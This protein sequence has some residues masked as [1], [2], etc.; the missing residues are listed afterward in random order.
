MHS[1]TGNMSKLQ[2]G[3][4]LERI[5]DQDMEDIERLFLSLSSDQV[6]LAAIEVISKD[7]PV[8]AEYLT[9]VMEVAAKYQ[10]PEQAHNA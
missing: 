4:E 8:M 6:R 9:G 7:D 5:T 1:Y 2:K 10:E 3:A